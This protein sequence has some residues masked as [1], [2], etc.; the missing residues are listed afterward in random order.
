M[1]KK[2]LTFSLVCAVLTSVFLYPT[3]QIVHLDSKLPIPLALFLAAFIVVSVV[4]MFIA[5]VIAKKISFL[6]QIAKFAQVGVLNT[7][8]DFGIYNFLISTTN[9]NSG[10]G[11]I[12]INAVSFC[13][14]LV[15]SYF[16]NKRWV[17]GEEKKSN[18]VTFAVVTLVGLSI[19]TGV[20]FA[21]TTFF[22]PIAGIS[23]TL[24]ANVAKV[25]ATGL[26]LVWNFL[27]YKLIVFKTSSPSATAPAVPAPETAKTPA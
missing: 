9:I 17:F 25:G 12:F 14:A 1:N 22:S 23:D 11:I 27:G 19:N 15:N 21:L 20:V 16:W 6:W 13:A 10:V 26:S 24:W 7:A 3:L 5:T 4:G 2:D 18:F 8:I